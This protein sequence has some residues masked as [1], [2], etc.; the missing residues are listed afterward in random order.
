MVDCRG[1]MSRKGGWYD[2]TDDYYDE[3]DEDDD[4]YYDDDDE[5]GAYDTGSLAP[6]KTDA[7][8]GVKPRGGAGGKKAGGIAAA[9][10]LQMSQMQST[11]P[12]GAPLGAPG[13]S[14]MAR[15]VRTTPEEKGVARPD[16]ITA[17][18]PAAPPA[19][20]RGFG[21]DTPSPDD[22]ALAKRRGTSGSGNGDPVHVSAS[23][24]KGHP[25]AS[26]D[27]SRE[28]GRPDDAARAAYAPPPRE[29]ERAR[30]SGARKKRLH[31]VVLGHV[32]AGK[33][34]LFGRVMHL[35][36]A[37]SDRDRHRHAR[38]A[39]AAGKASFAWAWALDARPEER[40][41]GVT[42]DV[43][44][45]CL[46]TGATL[47]HL[48]DAPGHR[49]F[50][51]NAIAGAAQADAACLVVDASRGAFESGFRDGASAGAGGGGGTS[52]ASAGQTR[53]HVRLAR[54]LGVEHLIV[55]VSKMDACAY[56]RAR[57]EEIRG[58][59]APFLRKSGFA[60][61]R[62]AWVPVSGTD[63]TNLVPASVGEAGSLSGSSR[64]SSGKTR[65]RHDDDDAR[66][67]EA[68]E[69]DEAIAS[70]RSWYPE[71]DARNA[72]LVA[73]V[74]A[75]PEPDRGR[76]MPLRF[77]VSE[78]VGAGDRLLGPCAVGG[79]VEAG[80]V[81]AGDTVA[82]APAGII[83]TVKAVRVVSS[84]VGSARGGDDSRDQVAFAGDAADIGLDLPDASC[85]APGAVLCHA[86]YPLVPVS[87][88]TVKLV[89]LD[90]LRVPLLAGSSVVVHAYASS[91]E[92]RITKL[93]STLD[94]KTGDVLRRA[95]RCVS[96]DAGAVVELTPSR[97]LAV[98]RFEDYPK[99]GRVQLRRAGAT[100]AL[101]VV[102]ETFA[103]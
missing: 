34:T 82:V 80:S 63:G 57:F 12:L 86:S 83:A 89:T 99:L 35:L 24:E 58:A 93:V 6:K 9:K 31:L 67:R 13:A 98:E 51:P 23:G 87:R 94:K 85:L 37:M 70:F 17:A 90:A 102:V 64:S 15:T 96:R 61:D 74:D 14:A 40:A 81:G 42:V 68:R 56:A 25:S 26:T 77:P 10:A 45:V 4:D 78:L 16:T 55:A 75:I 101:G 50:V 66:R 62:V 1:A 8:R 91:A 38:D 29:L 103:R 100:V 11:D 36:G 92:A 69:T 27:A 20:R 28:P 72:C 39:H 22:A 48:M 76:P 95:P 97:A 88:F 71:D 32:D 3:D 18:F 54:S 79:K 43:A 30:S 44:K 65:A 46:D 19:T 60:D 7:S 5:F 2:E 73:A 53:E 52:D 49:D 59:L 33:S 21:F 41:R 47:V 84:D